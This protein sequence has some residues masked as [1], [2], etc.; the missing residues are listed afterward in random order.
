ME[1]VQCDFCGEDD[2]LLVF[3]ATDT[4]YHFGGTFNVVRCKRCDLV[5]LTPR[6]DEKTISRYYPEA[7]YVCYKVEQE[8]FGLDQNHPF[9][10]MM[11]KVGIDKGH[12]CD[13]GAGIGDFLVAAQGSGWKVVGVEVNDYARKRS[14]ERLGE[15]V[16]FP[17]LEEAKF[18]SHSFD[19]VTL[20]NVLCVLPSPARAL[21]E[22]HRILKMGGVLAVA[23]PNFDSLERRIWG[24]NWITVDA[25][26]TLF[27]F[28]R[29]T[30]VRA[31]E[32]HGFEVLGVFQEPGADSLSANLLRT[33]RTRLLDPRSKQD[34]PRDPHIT[35]T[36]IQHP[37]RHDAHFKVA[38][39]TKDR[40]RSVSMRVLHPL[41]WAFAKAGYGK[42]LTLYARKVDR[43]QKFSEAA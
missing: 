6:P 14:N 37:K 15:E 10:R 32:R 31:V 7:D 20:W 30:L 35:P 2:T 9:L 22:I 25:P 39:Q 23:A 28:T 21:A 12:L 43:A 24:A 16:V 3:Q 26:R 5:Y 33:L 40:V 36:Q 13:V 4:N 27:H 38:D 34:G 11:T 29:N 17:T 8:S 18:P 19:A 42:G 1:H 41:A